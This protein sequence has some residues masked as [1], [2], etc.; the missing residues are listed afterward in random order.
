M[1][2]KKKL[3]GYSI[4]EVPVNMKERLGGTSS[5][6]FFKT[7]DYMIKVIFAIIIDSINIKRKGG[8]KKCN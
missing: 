1:L 8:N 3:S 6:R 5:I 2:I 7:A 4:E